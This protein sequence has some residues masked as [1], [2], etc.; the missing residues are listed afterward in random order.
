MK[1]LTRFAIGAAVLVVSGL[2]VLFVYIDQIASSA[3]EKGTSYA[4]GVDTDVG[5]VRIGFL[6]GTV[7]TGGL[8]IAN[9]PGFTNDDFLTVD[10]SRLEVSLESLRKDTV[11]VSLLAIDGVEV[12]LEQTA[13][14]KSRA[15]RLLGLS[16]K[17]VSR[18]A[19][20]A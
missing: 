9:P 5:F 18:L 13:G 1:L 11:V 6:T 17:S 16:R 2:V 19:P 14:N 7:R 12:A 8:D 3:I 10:S 20:D 15:A 4:L